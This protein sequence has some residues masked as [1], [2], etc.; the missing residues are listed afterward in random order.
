MVAVPDS[1][2][3]DAGFVTETVG[4]VGP[5]FATVTLNGLDVAVAPAVSLATAASVCAPSATVVVFQEIW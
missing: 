1:D 2:A 3:P 5:A 4:S